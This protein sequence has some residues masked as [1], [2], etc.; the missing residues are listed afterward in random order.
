MFRREISKIFNV[1]IKTIYL[2]TKRRKDT[3]NFVPI[4]NFQKGHS[5]AIK[6]FEKFKEFVDQNW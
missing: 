4:T 1:S 5:H 6:D 2:W 3:G